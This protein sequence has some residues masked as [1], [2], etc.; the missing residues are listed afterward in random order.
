VKRAALWRYLWHWTLGALAI[1]WL[2]LMAASYY[3]G[4]HEAEE[5]TDAHLASAVNVLLQVSAFGTQPGDPSTLQIPVEQEFR[6]FIPLGRHLSFTRSLAVIVWDNGVIVAD[7]RPLDQRWPVTQ[8]DG[9]S[10]F[11]APSVTHKPDHHW[12]MFAAQRANSSR[13]A[14]AMIDLEQR[15]WIGRHVALAIARPALVVL[16]LV[17]LLLWW[18]MRR[19]LQP[20]NQLSA[21]VAG[22]NLNGRD[23]LDNV[24]QF[25]E[26]ASVV[27]A[28]NGLIDRLQAQVSRERQFASDVAHELRTPLAAIAL[29]SQNAATQVD[30]AARALALAALQRE[31]LRAGRILGELLDLARAQSREDDPAQAVD[32]RDLAARVMGGFAQASHDSGHVLELDCPQEPVVV[33]GNP[34][35]LEL[36]LG[37]LISNALVH[38]APETLVGITVAHTVAGCQLAVSDNGQRGVGETPDPSARPR[39]AP[40]GLGIGLKLVERIAGLHQA[41][42]L[43]D[44]GVPPMTT[45]F[46][47]QWAPGSSGV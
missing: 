12:R 4:L 41:R 15:A 38:T 16:P 10:T 19:G 31:S 6:S 7:S 36:A 37:N 18:A 25:A 24:H 43:R 13:R 5:I 3:A 32:L 17:A 27:Q 29:Q 20:L 23:R 1:A 45:R 44:C 42:L 8:A 35:L 30:P 47:L 33:Q 22:L 2:A 21:R 34:L 9:Y 14:V 11:T 39:G 40:A 46:T 28:I 26:F